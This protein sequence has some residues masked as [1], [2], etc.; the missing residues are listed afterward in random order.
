MPFVSTKS[1][2]LIR[3]QYDKNIIKEVSQQ[4]KKA[5]IYFGLPGWR[6]LDVLCWKDYL[7]KIIA[8]ER[9][10]EYRHFLLTT[11]FHNNL[12]AQ[13]QLLGG[14]IDDSLI[15][16]RDDFGTPFAEQTFDLVNLDYEG[17]IFYKDLKGDSKRINAIKKLLERQSIGKRDFLLLSTFN[18]RNRDEKE[19]DS[20]LDTIHSVLASY[21]IDSTDAIKWYKNARYDFKIKIYFLYVLGRIASGNR[22]SCSFHPPVTYQGSS[23]IRMVHFA[24]LFNYSEHVVAPEQSLTKILNLSMLEISG[25]KLKKCTTPEI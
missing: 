3:E 1:K 23:K 14:D 8:V 7:E 10:E 18:S 25:S 11:A 16:G 17:G 6:M 21:R 4:K 9:N 22:F 2:D 15:N 5:L 12:D 13:L 24:C 19:F 20:T